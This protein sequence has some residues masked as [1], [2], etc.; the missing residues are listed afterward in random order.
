MLNKFILSILSDK[1]IP[2]FTVICYSK[3]SFLRKKYLTIEHN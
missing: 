2:I 1:Y 3:S